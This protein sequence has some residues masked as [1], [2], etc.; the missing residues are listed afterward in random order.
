MQPMAEAYVESLAAES[1]MQATGSERWGAD[2]S[3]G[4]VFRR[5]GWAHRV[6]CGSCSSRG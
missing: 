4:L 6:E 5:P 2:T 3:S 1:T